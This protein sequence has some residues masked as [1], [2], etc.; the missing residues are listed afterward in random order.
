MMRRAQPWLGTVVEISV[1]DAL[2]EPA[3]HAAIAAAYAEVA[4]VQRLMS[5]HDA[6]SDVSR[7][8]RAAPDEPV[9]VHAHTAAVLQLA[10]RVA[11]ASDG[12][13]DIGC[14]A[15]LVEWECLPA[16]AAAVAARSLPYAPDVT[17]M[18]RRPAPGWIDLGGI[19]KG[20]AVDLAIDALHRAGVRSACVNAGG[21]LRVSGS[22][23]WPVSVRDPRSPSRTGTVVR[24]C[25]EAM[26]T[27]ASY[28]SAKQHR[29]QPVCALVDGR[30]GQPVLTGSSISVRAPR[31]VLADALT[32]IVAAS[33]NERHPAL[34]AF[35]ASAFI[36]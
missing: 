25:D 7:L 27:S 3:L 4:L 1:A 8:N 32:K 14:A 15:R 16:S 29:G 28:F 26:A 21:D 34:A 17:V 2:P 24:L 11:A 30:T 31:C 20:Y 13:F 12:I 22:D 6:A 35:G 19:A 36:L 33:G 23:E 9:P 10:Q 5:F 18:V